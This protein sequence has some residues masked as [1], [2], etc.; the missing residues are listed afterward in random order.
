MTLEQFFT[1]L[2]KEYCVYFYALSVISFIM[3]FLMV[4]GGVASLIMHGSK[5]GYGPYLM[6]I[7]SITVGIMYFKSRLLY[8]M[9]IN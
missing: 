7:H 1:P 3:F 8:S 2:G 9:C 5:A 6:I 4:I